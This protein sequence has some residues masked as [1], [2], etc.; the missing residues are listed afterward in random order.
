M[1]DIVQKPNPNSNKDEISVRSDNNS[2]QIMDFTT[3]TSSDPHPV[4]CMRHDLGRDKVQSAIDAFAYDG[5]NVHFYLNG[6]LNSGMIVDTTQNDDSDLPII[7]SAIDTS[8]N[9]TTTTVRNPENKSVYSCTNS[10][11]LAHM[12][13]DGATYIEIG[14]TEVQLL[15][16]Y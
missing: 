5:E 11:H 13:D 10:Q 4:G 15:Q 7:S 14:S 12:M 1:P 2:T 9:A 8:L 6:I 3:P 16:D